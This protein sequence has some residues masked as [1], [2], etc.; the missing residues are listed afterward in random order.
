MLGTVACLWT[1][2]TQQMPLSLSLFLCTSQWGWTINGC[3]FL[4][5]PF[6]LL[7]DA[8]Q[9]GCCILCALLL[10]LLLPSLW[11]TPQSNCTHQTNKSRRG[12]YCCQELEAVTSSLSVTEQLCFL[13]FP[14]DGRAWGLH[15]EDTPWEWEDL[16]WYF[17]KS[18]RE[19][20]WCPDPIEIQM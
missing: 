7:V 8:C 2:L 19:V 20:G 9:I 6:L 13:P 1:A 11:R 16:V 14:M 17:Q 18:L 3:L 4:H 12:T 10:L 15:S 5:A